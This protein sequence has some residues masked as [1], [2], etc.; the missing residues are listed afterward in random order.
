MFEFERLYLTKRR[1]FDSY[2]NTVILNP[3]LSRLSVVFGRFIPWV[4]LVILIG[5]SLKYPGLLLLFWLVPGPNLS[6]FV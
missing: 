4:V 1:K 3:E 5:R 2:A 6:F